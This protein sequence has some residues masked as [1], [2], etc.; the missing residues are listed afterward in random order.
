MKI[1]E[2]LALGERVADELNSVQEEVR[3]GRP[4]DMLKLPQIKALRLFGREVDWL[5]GTMTIRK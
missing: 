5:L 3:N 4:G 2:I 1:L